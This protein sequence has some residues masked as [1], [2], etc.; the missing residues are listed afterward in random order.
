M[1]FRTFKGNAWIFLKSSSDGEFVSFNFFTVLQSMLRCEK[2]SDTSSSS[3]S[4]HGDFINDI[5]CAGLKLGAKT[6][7]QT[8]NPS[9]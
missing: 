7:P 6:A 4:K 2:D 5:T 9:T 1:H 3:F 8:V